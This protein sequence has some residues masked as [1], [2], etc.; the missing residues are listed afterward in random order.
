MKII[1]ID[2][3]DVKNARTDTFIWQAGLGNP[4]EKYWA[5]PPDYLYDKCLAVLDGKGIAYTLYKSR[6]AALTGTG[7]KAYAERDR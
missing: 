1:V 3:K 7:L 4:I 2:V 5:A 6:Q